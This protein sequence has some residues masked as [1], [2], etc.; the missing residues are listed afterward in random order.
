VAKSFQRCQQALVIMHS[1]LCKFDHELGY[2]MEMTEERLYEA[3]IHRMA[4]EIALQ[5]PERDQAKAH[6]Y[7]ERALTVA[8]KQRAKSWEL[9]AA[10]SMARLCRNQGKRDQAR[11]VLAPVYGWFTAGFDTA[12]EAGPT[13]RC[14][15]TELCAVGGPQVVAGE[16]GPVARGPNAR[17]SH[18]MAEDCPYRD[19]CDP[20]RDARRRFGLNSLTATYNTAATEQSRLRC[21]KG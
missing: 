19:D 1:G 13:L 3:E 12:A 18:Q 16:V 11:E 5:S 10:M 6:P 2:Q 21:W 7:F 15:P 20:Q 9:R 14:D 17:L 4:G 8:R